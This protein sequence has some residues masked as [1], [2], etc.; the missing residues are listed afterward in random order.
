MRVDSKT[1]IKTTERSRAHTVYTDTNSVSRPRTPRRHRSIRRRPDHLRRRWGAVTGDGPAF[2]LEDAGV[3]PVNRPGQRVA[4]APPMVRAQ[5][6][7]GLAR[8]P[9]ERGAR[10]H[11]VSLFGQA[12]RAQQVL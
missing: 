4:V 2:G 7:A 9:D 3:L 5:R 1:Y 11:A 10:R 8:Q 12:G 6:Y